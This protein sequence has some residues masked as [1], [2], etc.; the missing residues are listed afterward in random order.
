[1]SDQEFRKLVHGRICFYCKDKYATAYI[2]NRP[3]CK[4]CYRKQKH[5]VKFPALYS[6]IL[7]KEVENNGMAKI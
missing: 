3:S 4:A 5:K 7:K 2:N 6:K 1:M